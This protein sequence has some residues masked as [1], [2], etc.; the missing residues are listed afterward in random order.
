MHRTWWL[1]LPECSIPTNLLV[2]LP[3]VPN[4]GGTKARTFWF[5]HNNYYDLDMMVIT[6][7]VSSKWSKRQYYI[8]NRN[9]KEI[10]VF[11]LNDWT[12]QL[13]VITNHKIIVFS[14]YALSC[15]LPPRSWFPRWLVPTTGGYIG[16]RIWFF[17]HLE[18]VGNCLP[19]L[20][21]STDGEGGNCSGS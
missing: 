4:G 20:G 13:S 9:T 19:W 1:L 11:L 7:I 10:L 3:T 6:T 14:V 12:Y 5:W 18:Y 17:P 16:P 15:Y 8:N 21:F 2:W